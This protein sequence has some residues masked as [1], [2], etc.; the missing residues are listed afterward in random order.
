MPCLTKGRK[1]SSFNYFFSTILIMWMHFHIV[2]RKTNEWCTE[3]MFKAAQVCGNSTPSSGLVQHY[4]GNPREERRSNKIIG[5][6]HER[7]ATVKTIGLPPLPPSPPAAATAGTQLRQRL[8]PL[9]FHCI[10][11]SAWREASLVQDAQCTEV[12]GTFLLLWVWMAACNHRMRA[13]PPPTGL[14][15]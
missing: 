4:I 5:Y 14:L 7:C 1:I 2:T 12:S 13:L 8:R 11:S 9:G 6:T 3:T 10:F 15:I